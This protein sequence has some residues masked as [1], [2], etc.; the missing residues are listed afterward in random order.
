MI[1]VVTTMKRMLSSGDKNICKANMHQ[2]ES[3]D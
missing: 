3:E 1:L 2:L